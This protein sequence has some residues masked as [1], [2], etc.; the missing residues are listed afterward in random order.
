MLRTLQIGISGNDTKTEIH[1]IVPFW[2]SS[3]SLSLT[4]YAGIKM[5]T[6]VAIL[7]RNR[8]PLFPLVLFLID[9]MI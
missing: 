1:Q 3:Y 6:S 4:T 5:G 9:L 8:Y 2:V 7:V